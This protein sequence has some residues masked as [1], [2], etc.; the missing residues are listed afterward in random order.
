MRV[1]L[2]KFRQDKILIKS[3]PR[4]ISLVAGLLIYGLLFQQLPLEFFSKVVVGYAIAGLAL[5]IFD[6]GS[7]TRILIQY[8]SQEREH[9]KV[10]WT[11]RTLRI[12]AG[13]LFVSLIIALV[14]GDT[15][16]ALIFF[17]CLIDLDSDSTLGIRQTIFSN[18]SAVTIQF[19][20]K[21]SQ[22]IHMTS[23]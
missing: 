12:I 4:F 9:A 14:V 21:M 23:I 10:E 19:S 8:S 20:K 18:K 11:H 5:W 15:F 3:I 13:G 1:M 16:L 7:S 22:I 17:A 2:K 6:F